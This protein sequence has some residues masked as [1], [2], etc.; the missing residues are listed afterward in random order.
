[1]HSLLFSAVSNHSGRIINQHHQQQRDWVVMVVV[2]VVVLVILPVLT[3]VVEGISPQDHPLS[4]PLL[5]QGRKQ[6]IH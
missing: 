4:I 2:V 6:Q 3:V 5:N 1:M